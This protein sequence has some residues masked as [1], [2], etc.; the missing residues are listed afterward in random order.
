MNPLTVVEG[1][2]TDL[3]IPPLL[4]DL[5]AVVVAV[6][7]EHGM[8]IDANQ[9]F[10]E[11]LALLPKFEHANARSLFVQPDF[12]HFTHTEKETPD[13]QGQLYQGILN[14][15]NPDTTCRSLNGSVYRVELKYLIVG[16]YD[17]A[18]LERLSASVLELNDELA[19]T[20]RQLVKANRTLKANE[21][22][23][24]KMMLTDPLTNIPNRRAFDQKLQEEMDRFA[25]YKEP[26]CLALADIDHFK[27]VNDTYGHDVGDVVI[28][29]FAE[30]LH[31]N[32]RAPDFV[33]R[34]GGEEFIILLPNTEL[35]QGV[36]VVDRLRKEFGEQCYE[37]IDRPVTASFGITA[38]LKPDT[39][40]S[41]I[42]RADGGLYRAKES[43]RNQVARK[44]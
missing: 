27:S 24:T 33:A 30:T 25:R 7:D 41:V 15:G 23:I 11:L 20:Q 1:A 8:V 26:C 6:L 40:D 34:V 18:D 3:E 36:L 17:V 12:S 9:G 4:K 38:M 43:G 42:K 28:Q 39:K 29:R 2:S 31:N 10:K 19:Q 32:K 22:K 14:L 35:E 44:E 16:E 37:A 21:A 13:S 5:T